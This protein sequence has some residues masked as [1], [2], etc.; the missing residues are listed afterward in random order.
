MD[1]DS[2]QARPAQA[3]SNDDDDDESEE[4]GIL[5]LLDGELVV[6]LLES[7]IFSRLNYCH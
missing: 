5:E 1:G 4:G 7:N 2:D 6:V 3:A